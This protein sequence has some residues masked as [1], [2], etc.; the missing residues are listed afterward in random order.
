MPRVSSHI[1]SDAWRRLAVARWF[2]QTRRRRWTASVTLTA[3]VLG[4]ASGLVGPSS[5]FARSGGREGQSVEPARRQLVDQLGELVA[6]SDAVLLVSENPRAPVVDLVLWRNDERDP[7][8]VNPE[9]II[10]LS[11]SRT[12]RTITLYR[13]DYRRRNSP[14]QRDVPLGYER[15][16]F[17]PDFLPPAS[18]RQADFCDR[19]RSSAQVNGVVLATDVRELALESPHTPTGQDAKLRIRLTW[20]SD[21]VD[22]PDSATTVVAATWRPL[23]GKE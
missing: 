22:T 17:P 20:A 10:V 18:L 13:L 4:A 8:R 14:H 6:T 16:T 15:A 21:S 9:E 23:P 7:G 3:L 19:W 5:I 12:L 2:S 11:H 1:S